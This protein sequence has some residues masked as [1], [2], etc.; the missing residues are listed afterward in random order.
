MTPNLA[1]VLNGT[2]QFLPYV[3]AL[4][5]LDEELTVDHLRQDLDILHFESEWSRGGVTRITIEIPNPGLALLGNGF[6]EYLAFL[7]SVDGTF[8]PHTARVMGVGRVIPVLRTGSDAASRTVK[9]QV[10][11]AP[12]DLK[13]QVFQY[14][15]QNLTTQ[16]WFDALYQG[17]DFA[18]PEKGLDA[19]SKTF[20]VDPWSHVISFE[21]I[22]DGSQPLVD[23][24]DYTDHLSH[25]LSMG[26]P[27]AVRAK[28][29]VEVQWT[30][31]AYVA[32]NAAPAVNA[33][34]PITT[35]NPGAM[36]N[37]AEGITDQFVSFATPGSWKKDK[38]SVALQS[39]LSPWYDSGQTTTRT[40]QNS[41]VGYAPTYDY[42]GNVNG[43]TMYF[44]DPTIYSITH[45]VEVR[46]GIT[47]YSYNFLF[48]VAD[49]KQPRREILTVY[50]DYPLQDVKGFDPVVDL[51]SIKM[52]D[53]TIMYVP[54]GAP[55]PDPD[56]NGNYEFPYAPTGPVPPWDALTIWESGDV[57]TLG[58]KTYQCVGDSVTGPFYT[59]HAGT[60]VHPNWVE[61]PNLA[62]VPD[63]MQPS[64]FDTGRGQLAIEHGLLRCRAALRA[65][66]CAM[67]ASFACDWDTGWA[68]S[69][70]SQCRVTMYDYASAEG[71]PVIGKPTRIK[72]TIT[73]KQKLCEVEM[74]V[75][76]GTGERTALAQVTPDPAT[77][78]GLSAAQWFGQATTSLL[79]A[80][81]AAKSDLRSIYAFKA[82]Y[83]GKVIGTYSYGDV[84]WTYGSEPLIQYVD[85]YQLQNPY[86]AVQ[87]VIRENEAQDQLT[88]AANAAWRGIDPRGIIDNNPTSVRVTMRDITPTGVLIRRYDVAAEVHTSPMGIDLSQTGLVK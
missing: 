71:Q 62:P 32:V 16:P 12:L 84:A 24:D 44:L 29:Q 76:L 39:Y 3:A 50:M 54:N 88:M 72:R 17:M 4:A 79:L 68:V 53:P 36:A 75:P 51:G 47:S 45:N 60:V 52:V 57:V 1:P 34:G 21:D 42:F 8:T 10:V 33:V 23:L 59:Y 37:A 9:V 48:Y 56:P 67:T 49:Y 20:V 40:Y 13:N 63:A 22:I 58:P 61:T 43:Q 70:L 74:S 41:A 73:D 5:S 7:E 81:Q 30:Q 77:L 26:T 31:R 15:S 19:Y 82:R 6:P 38:D 18:K 83:S 86:Y 80:D 25:K 27:P 46:Y 66:S 64:L 35:L 55:P 87:S 85:P 78:K 65:R 2:E 11:C 14:A 28:L 69:P